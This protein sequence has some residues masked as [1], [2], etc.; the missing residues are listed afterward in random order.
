MHVL[1][2]IEWVTNKKMYISPTQIAAM[3]VD[4]LWYRSALFYSRIRP[5]DETFHQWDDI[6]YAGGD[7]WSFLN[8]PGLR[9]VLSELMAWLRKSDQVCVWDE[10]VRDTLESLY[11]WVFKERFPYDILILNEYTEAYVRKTD[12]TENDPY[13]ISQETG[14]DV[15]E[16]EGYAVNEV[17]LLQSALR[18]LGI[19]ADVLKEAPSQVFL[20]LGLEPDF[21]L[22]EQ[23]GV[24]HA[25]D[26]PYLDGTLTPVFYPEDQF[27]F[28][29]GMT[30]CACMKDVRR[31]VAQARN[32]DQ[33]NSSDYR[34]VYL[35]KSGVF[36]RADC[37][38]VQNMVGEIRGT[39]HYRGSAATGRRPC[40]VCKP[41]EDELAENENRAAVPKWV[42]IGDQKKSTP[43]RRQEEEQPGKRTLSKEE[44]RSLTRFRQAQTERVA[45]ENDTFATDIEKSDFYTLTRSGYGFFAGAGYSTYHLRHCSKLKGIQNIDGFSTCRE[46]ER[47]GLSPCRLCRPS[48]KDNILYPAHINSKEQENETTDILIAGCVR[49]GYPYEA[50]KAEF[51]FETPVGRWKINTEAS[52]YIVYHINLV[53]TPNNQF[54][55]HRQPRLFLSLGDTFR[56]IQKH[57]K[58]LMAKYPADCRETELQQM[59]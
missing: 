4:D 36:H 17:C 49:N 31:G 11:Q 25:S 21:Y 44:R 23:F 50:S 38:F 8:A 43:K 51:F 13:V 48:E 46:A 3:R 37:R 24:V 39:T 30:Y 5:K 9:K 2:D 10:T 57:D 19:P 32:Q 47:R 18:G 16:G 34:Y 40:Q 22:D 26:C 41:N 7:R 45:R 12:I 56:Y 15:P 28:Q 6:S 33:I 20:S 29:N 14:E 54:A 58:A 52:P 1:L 53:K 42:A 55:Y 27:F 35:E 59:G